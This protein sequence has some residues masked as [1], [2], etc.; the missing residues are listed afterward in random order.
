MTGKD[1]CERGCNGKDARDRGR[2][3]VRGEGSVQQ[4]KEVWPQMARKQLETWENERRY[5]YSN[6]HTK[7]IHSEWSVNINI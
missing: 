2:T 4:R 5:K 1:A 7:K 6:S 3:R